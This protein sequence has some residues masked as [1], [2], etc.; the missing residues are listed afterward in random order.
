[1]SYGYK[2]EFVAPVKSLGRNEF[3]KK[4]YKP[5]VAQKTTA[6]INEYEW[7][8]LFLIINW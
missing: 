2:K 4:N 6:F 1:M 7:L 5:V 3:K 8:K